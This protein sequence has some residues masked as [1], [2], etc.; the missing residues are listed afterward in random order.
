M[1]VSCSHLSK[2]NFC[3]TGNFFRIGAG[4]VGVGSTVFLATGETTADV[5]AGLGLGFGDEGPGTGV[6]EPEGAGV[7]DAEF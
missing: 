5:T 1:I 4:G 6:D 2:S 3:L 7:L